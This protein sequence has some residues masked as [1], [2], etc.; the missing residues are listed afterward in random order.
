[1]VS[2]TLKTTI[3]FGSVL[4]SVDT[5]NFL[6]VINPIKNAPVAHPQFAQARQI[7]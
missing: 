1:M 2:N 5:H 7:V 4:D 6:R 3:N